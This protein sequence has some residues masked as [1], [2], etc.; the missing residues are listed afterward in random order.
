MSGEKFVART[1]LAEKVG[2]YS[3]WISDVGLDRDTFIMCALASQATCKIMVGPGVVN[4]YT[5]HPGTIAALASTLQELSHGRTFLGLGAGGYRTLTQLGI[6]TWNRPSTTL[7]EAVQIC[8]R[9]LDGETTTFDGSVFKVVSARISSQPRKRVPIYLGAMMGRQGLATAGELCD[10]A[11]LVGPLGENMTKLVVETVKEGAANAGKN[12]ANLEIALT[13]PFAVSKDNAKAIR[14]AKPV[15][16]ELAVL[17]RRLRPAMLAEGIRD[18]DISRVQEAVMKG[19]SSVNVVSDHMVE[20]F[21]IAGTPRECIE[22]I[23][24]LARI[25]ITQ[26][27]V[28]RPSVESPEMLHMIGKEI[29]GGR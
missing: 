21:G 15:V 23:E 14:K 20:L 2:F 12:P 26:L 3:T 17:D 27:V 24:H 28:G 4:P 22:K 18:Q 5:R 7:R 11:F 16:A 10:G 9:L 8:R 25:G 1:K 29:I 6:P 13:A 19:R